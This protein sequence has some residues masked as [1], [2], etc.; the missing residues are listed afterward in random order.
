MGS[1]KW[2]WSVRG[3]KQNNEDWNVIRDLEGHLGILEGNDIVSEVL[4][5]GQGSGE[6]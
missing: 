3:L 5:V 2:K 6:W 1:W 4:G